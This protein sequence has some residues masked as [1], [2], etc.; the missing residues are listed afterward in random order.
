[1]NIR[2]TVAVLIL[3]IIIL[4]SVNFFILFNSGEDNSIISTYFVSNPDDDSRT[5]IAE[6][7]DLGYGNEDGEWALLQLSPS[8]SFGVRFINISI[9]KN[10]LIKDA[11]IELFS[12]GT[13]WAS[14]PNCIIYCDKTGDALNFSEYGVLKR[15]GRNYTDNSISWN[16]TL[17]Y[18][19]WVK[20]P[21]LKKITQEI[22]KRDDWK[23]GNAIAYLFVTNGL[24]E[25]S[26]TFQNFE[27]GY[28]SKLVIK[29][30]LQQ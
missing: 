25:Y 30:E 7:T 3:T 18:N 29:W 26:A 27:S 2:E 12:V 19:T 28:A 16:E 8:Y 20:T 11:Y 1:M 21:S 4:A 22:I 5:F 9:P 14:S 17:Q 6:N 15:C 13:P 23:E 10:A 24:R